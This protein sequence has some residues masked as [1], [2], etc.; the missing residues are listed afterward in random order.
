VKLSLRSKGDI[1]ANDICKRYFNGGGHYNAAG[2][3]STDS[4]EQTVNKLK[5]I[6]PEYK[7]LLIK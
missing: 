5:L 7:K 4:L 1:P 3:T 6:L 2:G